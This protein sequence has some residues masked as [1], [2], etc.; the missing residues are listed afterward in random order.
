MLL[1]SKLSTKCAKL[2]GVKDQ[3]A[4]W[5]KACFELNMKTVKLIGEMERVRWELEHVVIKA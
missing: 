5:K 1:E 4:E 3:M 2:Q